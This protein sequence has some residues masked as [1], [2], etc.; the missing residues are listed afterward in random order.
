VSLPR[1]GSQFRGKIEGGRA[2]AAA[3]TPAMGWTVRP[4]TDADLP[5]LVRAVQA[6]FSLRATDVQVEESRAFLELDR[7]LLAVDGD[8]IVGTAGALS[9]EL[10][11]PGPVGVPAAGLTFVG[12]VPTHRRQGILT[13]LMAQ[14]LDDAR[15]RGEPLVVLLASEATI[16]GR[17]GFGVAVSTSGIEVERAHAAFRRPVDLAGRVQ[18]VEPA[19]M[20]ATLPGIFDRYR[21][22]QPGEVSRPPGWWARRLADR[23]EQRR[24]AGARFA[25]V[26]E[27]PGRAGPDGYAT[28]RVRPRWDDGLPGHVLEVED[29]VAL[30]P[31]ARAGLWQFCFGVDL[32]RLV[33]AENV[34]QDEPLPW[35]LRDGRRVRVTSSKDFLWVRVLDVEAALGAR[36]YGSDDS[37]VVEVAGPPGQSSGRFRLRCGGP[38]E[39]T[40]GR[41]DRAA[42]LAVDLVHLGAAYLGGVRFATLAR[43]GVVDELAPGALA[44][45]DALFACDPS[46]YCCTPF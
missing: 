40:C 41:T 32:V 34:P 8:R 12:V 15:A 7:T 24:G 46:P 6:A 33:R 36:A 16:Y 4:S 25:A 21:R 23:E 9:L 44:R 39:A 11:V 5:A 1:A 10:T 3:R 38:G 28:Y 22:R 18:L 2:A 27:G 19:D 20:A 45:A 29:L 42:D 43:A 35:M 17:F 31:E 37:V 26:W 14:Q 30:T 13:A